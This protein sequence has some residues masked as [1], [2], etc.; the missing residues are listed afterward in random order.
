MVD[1]NDEVLHKINDTTGI[2]KFGV[3]NI[4]INRDDKFPDDTL[5]M[6]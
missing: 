2:E 4:L 1:D 6:L 3:T 5:K